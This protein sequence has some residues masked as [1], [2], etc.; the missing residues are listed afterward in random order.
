MFTP[1]ATSS[2]ASRQISS[3]RRSMPPR[4]S[5]TGQVRVDRARLEH[6]VVHLAQL[7]QLRVAQD[8]LRHHELV[9]VVGRLAE[10]VDLRADAGLRLITTDSRIGS[11]AG[12]VTWANS[13]LK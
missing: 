10:Q 2:D 7:L 1:R 8:R 4:P 9:A 11:M 13:C 3:M 6:A 12:F 5:P